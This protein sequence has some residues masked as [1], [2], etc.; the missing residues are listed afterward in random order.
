[1]KAQITGI[2]RV[3]SKF[4]GDFYYMFFKGEEGD[5]YKTALYPTYR[6]FKRWKPLVVENKLG[7]CLDGLIVKNK[8]ERLIDAD[9]LFIISEV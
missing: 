8:K 5:T 9:S 3:P 4:G 2:N 6:N 1:M 7:A